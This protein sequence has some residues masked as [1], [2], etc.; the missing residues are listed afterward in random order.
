VRNRQVRGAA[1]TQPVAG[2][3]T[4]G[5][6]YLLLGAVLLVGYALGVGRYLVAVDPLSG[7]DAI[8]VLGG[9]KPNRAAYAVHLYSRGYAP[10][11]LF[12]GGRL[13]DVGLACSTAQL[14]REDA[15][16]LGLPPAAAIVLP[17]ARST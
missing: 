11:V 15:L 12:S 9:G 2:C 14:A 16:A 4:Y 17:E 8:V 5:A 3:L 13:A 6:L 7:A 10:R 1:F